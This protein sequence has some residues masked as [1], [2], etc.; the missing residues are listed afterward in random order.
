MRAPGG[1]K[2]IGPIDGA[3]LGGRPPGVIIPRV[4][5]L[6]GQRRIVRTEQMMAVL[7]VDVRGLVVWLRVVIEMC[8]RVSVH[9]MM[10]EVHRCLRLWH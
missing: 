7:R 5:A 4:G 2:D 3:V 6:D 1:Q 9:V 10:A 8:V